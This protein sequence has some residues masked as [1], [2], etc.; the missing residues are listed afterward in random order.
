MP[1]DG[2]NAASPVPP[3]AVRWIPPVVWLALI[4]IG[5]SWPDISIGPDDLGFD[6][7]AHCGAYAGLSALVLR[8]TRT[9]LRTSTFLGVVLSIAAIGAIDEWH[10]SFIPNRSMSL[11]DWFADTAGAIV[12]ASLVRFVPF[13]MPRHARRLAASSQQATP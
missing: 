3:A 11:A 1:P 10:Q 6:K 7:V 5:T 9:P 12:G 4:L 2:L 13:L 8:A